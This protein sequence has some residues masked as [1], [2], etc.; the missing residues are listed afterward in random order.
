[1]RGVSPIQFTIRVLNQKGEQLAGV[2]NYPPGWHRCSA[3]IPVP[4]TVYIETR[5]WG[6]DSASPSPYVIETQWDP[7]DE[8]DIFGRNDDPMLATPVTFQEVIRGNIS[9]VGDLDHYRIDVDHPGRLFV[10]GNHPTEIEVRLFDPDGKVLLHHPQYPGEFKKV[11]SVLPGPHMLLIEGWDGDEAEAAPYEFR[12]RLERAEPYERV[13]LHTDPIRPLRLGEGETFRLERNTDCDRFLLAVPRAGTVKLHYGIS[14]QVK[15]SIYD[16][17]S[18]KLLTERGWYPGYH[19]QTLEAKGPTRYRIELI[20]WDQNDASHLPCY[21]LTSM[22]EQRIVAETLKL[23]IDR[24]DPT[25]VTFS[26]Q[27]IEGYE[28][29]ITARVDANGDGKTDFEL[30]EGKRVR[31]RYPAE[32]IYAATAHFEGP[33]GVKGKTRVWVDTIGYRERKGVQL[34]VQFPGHGQVVTRP[35]LARASAVSYAGAPIRAVRFEVDGRSA[36]VAHVPPYAVELPWHQLGGDDHELRVTAI[37]GAGN[38]AEVKRQFTLSP[39]F[40]LLPEDGAVVTGRDVVVNWTGPG[41][42]PASIRY[43]K[44][45]EANWQDEVVGESARHRHVRLADLEPGQT[46]EFQPMGGDEPGPIRTVTRVKGLAF[47][48]SGYGGTIRRDYDQRLGISVRNHAD[49]PQTVRLVCGEPPPESKLLVGFVGEGSEG[50][51]IELGPGEAREF[52]LGLSAQDVVQPKIRFPIRVAS[53]SGYN[54]EAEVEVDVILPE[55]KLEW[56]PLGDAGRM[57]GQ[58]YRLRNKGDTLT[59][60]Q[61]TIDGEGLVV[62]PALDHAA[63]PSGRTMEFTVYPK[64]HD[65][66]DRAEG[67]LVARA[68]NKQEA[69]EVAIAVPEGKKVFSVPL[70]PGDPDDDSFESVLMKARAMAG[71]YLNPDSVDWDQAVRSEDT[72]GDGVPDRYH[73]H[74]ELDEIHWIGDDTDGDR[75]IDFV[76]ADIADDGQLD[77]A[78]YRTENGWDRTNLVEAWLEMGFSLPW[79]R[80]AYEK[81]D[82]DVVLNDTVVG[83]LRDMIPEGNY[84]FRLPP[85]AIRFG[86]RGTP[87]PVSVDINSKHLRGGHYV[88]SSDFRV[89]LRTTGGQAWVVAEDEQAAR[90]AARKLPGLTAT[91]PDYSISSA[92]LELAGELKKGGEVVINVPVRNVGATR[93]REVAVALMRTGD[94]GKDVELT[95]TYL[96]DVP[97]T[98]EAVACL[99]WKAGAGKHRLRVLVDPD[100]ELQDADTQNNEAFVSL[101]IPGDD[102][103][104]TIEILEP[105]A[106]ATIAESVVTVRAA[107]SDDSGVSRVDLRIDGGLPVDMPPVRDDQ[108]KTVA[109]EGKALLQP[110]TRRIVARVTDGSGNQVETA[111][112]V[113]VDVPQ[114]EVRIVSP[115]DGEEIDARRVNV[116]VETSKDVALAAIRVND[117]PWQR[118]TLQDGRGEIE[119]DL[120]FG[121]CTIEAMAVDRKGVR[122][123]AETGVNCL[124]QPTAEEQRDPETR[125][126]GEDDAAARASTGRLTIPG[127][128]EIDAFGPP[129]V[130]IALPIPEIR[131]V[132]GPAGREGQRFG[133]AP[134]GPLVR[135]WIALAADAALRQAVAASDDGLAGAAPWHVAPGEYGSAPATNLS[136]QEIPPTGDPKRPADYQPPAEPA[137]RMTTARGGPAGSTSVSRRPP[138]GFVGAK[139][140][141]QDK[142]CTNRPKVGVTF[143]LPEWLR[144]KNLPKPGTKEFDAMV[145]RLLSEMRAAGYDTSHL[146][147]FQKRLLDRISMLEQP[148]EVPGWLESFALW[149]SD[150]DDSES[151]K[152]WREKMA[153]HA[154]AWYLRLLASGNPELIAAGLKARAEAIGK[155]DEAMQDHAQAAIESIQAHQNL[156]EETLETLPFVGDALDLYGGLTGTTLLAGRELSA[157]ERTLR[158]GTLFGPDIFRKIVENSP[159][160]QKALAKLAEAAGVMGEAGKKRLANLL[161][162]KTD[163]IDKG[164]EAVVEFMTKERRLFGETIE[165]SAEQAGKAFA[166]TPKGLAAR[167]R[168]MQ[169]YAD[170]RDLVDRLKRMDP[171]ADEYADAVRALQG[172]KT[173][174]RIMNDAPDVPNDLRKQLKGYIEGR[175]YGTA[176]KNVKEGFEGLYKRNLSPD[177]FDAAA[178]QMGL[179]PAAARQ[180]KEEVEK[181]AKRYKIDPNDVEVDTLFI[182]NKR[183]PKPG[184]VPKTSF[185]RD[186][187]VT[188]QLK[189]KADVDGSLKQVTHD[190]DH[191][192]SRSVYEQEFY[193]ASTGKDLPRLA[194]GGVDRKA[195]T[196]WADEMDQAVTSRWHNEA[197]NTGEVQL[198]DFLDKSIR[199]T[200]TRVED[201]KDA[202]TYKGTHWFDKAKATADPTMAARH[203]TEGMR[204]TTKQ[205]KDLVLSRVSQYGLDPVTAVPQRLQKSMDIFK[206]VAD[207]K[208]PAEQGEAMLRKIGMNSEKAVKDVATFLEGLEK[209]AGNGYRRLR[210]KELVDRLDD[211]RRAGGR[212]ATDTMLGEIN[213]ALK[214]GHIS[215]PQFVTLRSNVKDGIVRQFQ[216]Q[217]PSTWRQA[218]QRWADQALSRRLISTTEKQMLANRSE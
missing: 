145:K 161:G 86:D 88:V 25:R 174:Q 24:T 201:V 138:G 124:R 157:I 160:A 122:G 99:T 43:R 28:R 189:A 7:G 52:M 115:A 193:R 39:Y 90:A 158:L 14:I 68:V 76:S 133:V 75:Q 106:D 117:G 29:A 203:M 147:R 134:G 19:V 121:D 37:D 10:E 89:G 41:F 34:H 131:G 80:S 58:R 110:G 210:T 142:Y 154:Q 36:G 151:L 56:E 118:V 100:G 166:K 148:G 12:V 96:E 61:V 26:R 67:N 54:D 4:Q 146:E 113:T 132:Q 206:R 171:N 105:A 11:V 190:I 17:T 101:E 70:R 94:R 139:V 195:I 98:G 1:M 16:D 85:A 177:E 60:L 215:G 170:A 109:F 119:I 74:H 185:G 214:A 155:F 187:D 83:T 42:G 156:V 211:L 197:Y 120:R 186:R 169:D 128:G 32:G 57:L 47:G 191:V 209:T 129:S 176:D 126:R 53:Q 13:P 78:A 44:Q 65:G 184:E 97:L 180:F 107:A 205:Y 123:T 141:K 49:K 8:M 196:E 152:A 218:L 175:W 194:D 135:P 27:P 140:R 69:T 59:D 216:V 165:E 149:E 23:D 81:H 188:F 167:Q 72:N 63:I 183:P 62:D 84:R 181:F 179:D 46:Y 33:Q 198:D 64:L 213:E 204:Q 144:R 77:Y 114:P 162:K 116:H 73:F 199:P 31:C 18:G 3:H 91:G 200:L 143:Q 104:P 40:G 212:N 102:Q 38:Q 168:L 82:V 5:E 30:P 207:G 217:S 66:F 15:A 35:D 164:L 159:G 95:R 136:S 48:R 20:E 2:S 93:T 6:D 137:P 22:D 125:E 92:E 172:N 178:R 9:H 55:V 130:P 182:T 127:I 208:I 45:G 202:F 103:R 163:E 173:A 108:G 79:R 153:M 87:E 150:E 71:A 51:P 192:Y 112:P 111:S 21:I 50:E